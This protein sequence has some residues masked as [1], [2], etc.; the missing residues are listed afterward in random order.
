[1]LKI[2]KEA[3]IIT[4]EN[5][6]KQAALERAV[7]RAATLGRKRPDRA[8]RNLIQLAALLYHTQPSESGTK[9]LTPLTGAI[10]CGNASRAL[11]LLNLHFLP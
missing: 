5:N 9:L 4:I 11:Q 3:I 10:A 2:R 1:M 6:I 8:A 7:L